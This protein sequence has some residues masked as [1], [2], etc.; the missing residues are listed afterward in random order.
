MVVEAGHLQAV[1]GGR[2]EFEVHKF[3][4]GHDFADGLFVTDEL[5][6]KELLRLHAGATRLV[7]FLEGGGAVAFRDLSNAGV[8]NGFDAG[9]QD[10]ELVRKQGNLGRDE[11][12]RTVDLKDTHVNP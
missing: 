7:D 6:G 8:I 1:F 3:G 10:R 12:V 2:D 5:G 4:L 9:G 11:K